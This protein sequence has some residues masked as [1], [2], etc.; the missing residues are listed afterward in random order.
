M[1]STV[2]IHSDF[3]ASNQDEDRA[4]ISNLSPNSDLWPANWRTNEIEAK[5]TANEE[6]LH[7]IVGLFPD[8][9]VDQE[10]N[11]T[12]YF[13]D[14]RW[15]GLPRR[16]TDFYY[17]TNDGALADEL[18]VLRHRQR[19]E[20]NKAGTPPAFDDAIADL[21]DYTEWERSWEKVQ[22]KSTPS[23]LGAVWFRQE[24]GGTKLDRAQV[25]A[26][27]AG[28]Q[29]SEVSLRDDP[30]RAVQLEHGNI[31]WRQVSAR[32]KNVAFRYRVRLEDPVDGR[33]LFELSLDKVHSCTKG[34]SGD[35]TDCREFY[36]V[37]VE[38]LLATETNIQ[39]L[40]SLS[41]WLAENYPNLVPSTQSKGRVEVPENVTDNVVQSSDDGHDSTILGE[42][43]ETSFLSTLESNANDNPG[44][45]NADET[46]AL[47]LSKLRETS[48][49]IISDDAD[50]PVPVAEAL[51]QESSPDATDAQNAVLGIPPTV[52]EVIVQEGLTQRSYVDQFDIMFSE[53]V[54]RSAFIA[55]GTI[56]HTSTLHNDNMWSQIVSAAPTATDPRR[57]PRSPLQ[58]APPFADV[59][60]ATVVMDLDSH[61]VR[62]SLHRS[63][64][65]N[66]PIG[67]RQDNELQRPERHELRSFTATWRHR[68]FHPRSQAAEATEQFNG[69]LCFDAFA[70]PLQSSRLREEADIISRIFGNVFFGTR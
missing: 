43:D 63:T 69:P 62:D 51:H 35:F 1:L 29:L 20:W 19:H 45:A 27:L 49:S 17:D 60:F 67:N 30:V 56:L 37:E 47:S 57:A 53:E 26:T 10:I 48:P 70:C 65:R 68:E 52:I 34:V 44:T 24:Y 9:E 13:V 59:A 18:H 32:L 54:N 23:R 14:I 46:I 39:E 22:Y 16:F 2:S 3:A 42:R 40:F 31:E 11:G 33:E 5:W 55:E 21:I 38:S 61:P 6:T 12:S 28:E 36:E 58:V 41:N 50:L 8:D 15:K 25:A 64:L 7:K 66:I 4:T